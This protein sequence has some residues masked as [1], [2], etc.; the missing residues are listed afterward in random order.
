[1]QPY[2]S[3]DIAAIALLSA[4]WGVVN[5]IFSPIV[6]SMFGLPILCDMIGFSVLS[7]T[8]WWV[9]KLG[10][11]T[12]VGLI[13]TVI[14]FAF[15]PYGV[16]FLGFAAA[17]IVFD[18]V[19]WLARYNTYFKKTSLTTISLFSFSILSAAVAGFIIGTYFMAAPALVKWGSVI[20]WVGLHAVG[21]T[22]GGFIGTGLVTALGARGFQ[23]IDAK[24]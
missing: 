2:N 11:A 19:S 13:A 3:H 8:V 14:N 22:I 7:V 10:A 17:S 16:F 21:G 23:R 18:V 24:K 6:F 15:N 4:L 20:G 5:S 12:I 9:R 1:V